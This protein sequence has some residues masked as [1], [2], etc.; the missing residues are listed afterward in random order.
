VLFVIAVLQFGPQWICQII[1]PPG[2]NYSRL[3]AHAP[4]DRIVREWK[5]IARA[6]GLQLKLLLRRLG[7]IDLEIA[8]DTNG[9]TWIK[10]D[11]STLISLTVCPEASLSSEFG[12]SDMVPDTVVLS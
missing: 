2:H 9:R 8:Y 1:I 11:R 10:L 7:H 12:A 5:F 6:C 3:I 4:K